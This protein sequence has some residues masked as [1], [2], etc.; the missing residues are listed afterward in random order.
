M[1]MY[2]NESRG[3]GKTVR[4]DD[5]M[6]RIFILIYVLIN[7]YDAAIVRNYILKRKDSVCRINDISVFYYHGLFL[8]EL[9]DNTVF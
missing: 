6:S 8:P 2:I 7:F 3:Y 9:S 1:H 4:I 5:L